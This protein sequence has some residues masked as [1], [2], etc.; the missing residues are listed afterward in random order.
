[1]EEREKGEKRRPS[2]EK[3]QTS[4]DAFCSMATLC[5]TDEFIKTCNLCSHVV[6]DG[7][8]DHGVSRVLCSE[9]AL[10]LE[11]LE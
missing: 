1:M 9:S 3:W 11:T 2:A 4:S 5:K 7:C 8:S 10:L 6:M